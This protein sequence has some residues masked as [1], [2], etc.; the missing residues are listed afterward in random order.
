M[1]LVRCLQAPQ[2]LN[3]RF[4]QGKAARMAFKQGYSQLRLKKPDLP[5]DGGGRHI[6]LARRRPHRTKRRH[7]DKVAVARSK[8]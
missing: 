5:T 4:R 7:R 2:Q 1:G 6:E 8:M 3:P